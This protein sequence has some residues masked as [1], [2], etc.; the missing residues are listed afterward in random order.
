MEKIPH[1]K[2]IEQISGKNDYDTKAVDKTL[3]NSNRMDNNGIQLNS[4][5]EY[6]VGKCVF[7]GKGMDN[8]SMS[9]IKFFWV[10]Q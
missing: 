3:I 10:F 4:E 9:H 2:K 5:F 6:F 8:F 7:F 1:P